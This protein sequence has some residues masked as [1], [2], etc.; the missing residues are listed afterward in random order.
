[1]VFLFLFCVTNRLAGEIRKIGRSCKKIFFLK[2]Q[3]K[4]VDFFRRGGIFFHIWQSTEGQKPL[5]KRSLKG[6]SE[7]F[8]CGALIFSPVFEIDN[9][10]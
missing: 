7:K 4:S 5:E 10:K 8:A 9:P 6:K 1:V 3:G 2:V